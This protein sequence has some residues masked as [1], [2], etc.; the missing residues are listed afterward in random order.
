MKSQDKEAADGELP[1]DTRS[2]DRVPG[3]LME[4]PP[5]VNLVLALWAGPASENKIRTEPLKLTVCMRIPRRACYNTDSR[6]LSPEML[7]L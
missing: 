3:R 6:A 7:T 5:E 1:V 4:R 2:L